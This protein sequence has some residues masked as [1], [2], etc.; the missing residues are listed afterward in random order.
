MHPPKIILA[1]TSSV[2]KMLLANAGV[3]FTSQ[4]PAVNEDVLKRDHPTLNAKALSILLAEKKAQS[5]SQPQCIIIGADQTLSFEGQIFNKPANADDLHH[6]LSLLRGKT[7]TLHTA[8]ALAL[9]GI[10]LWSYC[11]DAKLKMRQFS[12]A[13]LRSYLDHNTEKVL[14][15]LGGYQLEFEGIN[16]FEEIQGDYFAILGLP[17]VPLLARLRQQSYLSS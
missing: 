12:N 15:S 9:N 2:R 11:E 6:Q 7:H 13:F 5:I 16:L 10:I 14:S 1:S 8:I 3:P 17:L 4:T